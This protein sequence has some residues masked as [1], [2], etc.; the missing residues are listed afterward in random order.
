MWQSV[1]HGVFCCLG[2]S[3]GPAL[4]EAR[5][6]WHSQIVTRLALLL[7]ATEAEQAVMLQG[8]V[9]SSASFEVR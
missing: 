7:V 6:V 3:N 8:D 2:Q 4:Q 1:Y 9:T 5:W